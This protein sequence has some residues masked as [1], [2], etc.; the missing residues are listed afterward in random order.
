M[1]KLLPLVVV[2]AHVVRMTQQRMHRRSN[3][4]PQMDCVGSFDAHSASQSYHDADVR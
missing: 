4:S 1:A 3:I 2:A